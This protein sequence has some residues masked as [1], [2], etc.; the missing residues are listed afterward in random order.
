[1]NL[2]LNRVVNKLRKK[3]LTISI[4]ESCTGGLLSSYLISIPKVS[5]IYHMGLIAYSNKSK[6]LLLNIPKKFL[7]KYGSVNR[8]ICILMVKNLNKLTKTDISISTTGIAGPSGGA[9]AKPVGLVYVG[10]KIKKKI[11]CKK[12]L[13][14]NKSR[15][16]IQKET[17]KKTLKLLSNLVS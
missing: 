17:I 14:K 7:L 11:I 5:E 4:V 9:P 15:N 3:K 8:K 10:I 16:F 2:L 6:N 12:F 13:I 1:M